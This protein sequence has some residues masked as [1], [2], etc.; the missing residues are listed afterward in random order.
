MSPDHHM[1]ADAVLEADRPAPD[2]IYRR[3]RTAA[4]VR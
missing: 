2:L 3:I 4:L 1:M